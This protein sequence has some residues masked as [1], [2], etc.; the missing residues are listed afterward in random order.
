MN[1]VLFNGRIIFGDL[2]IKLGEGKETVDVCKAVD[3]WTKELISTGE[4]RGEARGRIE[5]MMSTLA[6]LVKKAIITPVQAA[7]QANMTV[8][9]FNAKTG[10]A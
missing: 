8:E 6:D 3:D 4:A 5:G 7:E 2:N 9:E 1:T 10:L